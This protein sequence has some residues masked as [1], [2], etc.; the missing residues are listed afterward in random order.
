V[1]IRFGEREDQLSADGRTARHAASARGVRAGRRGS[2]H[3]CCN[4]CSCTTRYLLSWPQTPIAGSPHGPAFRS[5]W[6]RCQRTIGSPTGCGDGIIQRSR[7]R[8]CRRP[9]WPVR[10]LEKAAVFA[11]ECLRLAAV[12]R[13]PAPAP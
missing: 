5:G 1:G 8:E 2:I 9:G 12:A 6:A 7:T 13:C 11:C 10:F 3:R 4:A